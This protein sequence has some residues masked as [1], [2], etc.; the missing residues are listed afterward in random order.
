MGRRPAC[1]TRKAAIHHVVSRLFR[2]IL[3]SLGQ[4][5]G[6]DHV[7]SQTLD[8]PQDADAAVV[9]SSLG[10]DMLQQ[11][12]FE[13]DGGLT[14]SVAQSHCQS[15]QVARLPN[16]ACVFAF[17]TFRGGLKSS[18]S[19]ERQA[20]SGHELIRALKGSLV[21]RQP[22]LPS[23]AGWCEAAIHSRDLSWTSLRRR[24]GR[25]V[26]WLLP[27]GALRCRANR[28]VDVVGQSRR[29]DGTSS[30]RSQH[31]CLG[32][33]EQRARACLVPET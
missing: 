13:E 25:E 26:I 3:V 16:S 12:R 31:S 15:P 14:W 9:A 6:Q 5:R 17:Q 19:T 29:Q 7:G 2:T 20:A 30:I 23:A 4:A 21:L 28:V 11:Q 32:C 10:E 24:P 18:E 22:V 8:P 1:Q 27:G 33:Y